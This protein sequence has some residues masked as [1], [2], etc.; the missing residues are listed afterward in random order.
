MDPER[1]IYRSF[2]LSAGLV[3]LFCLVII[4]SVVTATNRKL[5]YEQA[6]TEARSL[7]HSI[8]ITRKWNAAHGGIYVEKKDGMTSN[9]YLA[10]PDI[11]TTDGRLFTKK[12]PALMTREISEYAEQE[13]LFRFR[14]TSLNPL[15]P[16]NKPD[17]FEEKALKLFEQGEKEA[18][19]T[20]QLEGKTYFRYMA[21]LF[22][23]HACLTC[24][25]VQGYRMGQVRGGISVTFDV[26]DIK[27]IQDTY[28]FIFIAFGFI[29]ISV[30]FGIG[31]YFT[32]RLIRKIAEARQQI[33]T[34]AITDDLTGL[35]N[36]RHL[37]TRF[38]QEFE[39]AMRLKK[40]LGCMMLDID[41]FKDI[42]DTYGH[43]TGDMV[44]KETAGMIVRSIRAYDIAGRYGGEEFLVVLPDT[45]FENMLHLADRI[46]ETIAESLH[47]RAG[48]TIKDPVTVS[49][50]IASATTEDSSANDLLL[51]ADNGLY[52]A[53]G[54][55][56]NRV[57]WVTYEC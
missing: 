33:E 32:K 22:V 13:G 12:N 7:F 17:A 30:L 31:L 35:F 40:Q 3:F 46:R 10:D 27:K 53:K 39:R 43:P 48:I 2:A 23:E 44:L 55:G 42:N 19:Q 50:G 47:A 14:I 18:F 51:R 24:H 56:R 6:R 1:T 29:S 21:P 26:K 20:E 34:M 5:I 38:N 54:Q 41:H 8:V 28:T 15:N 37:L 25:A 52:K 11:K 49:I 36:R 16:D 4:F 45:T 9:P 57:S